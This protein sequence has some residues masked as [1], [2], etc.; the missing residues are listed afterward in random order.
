M[1]KITD[2]LSPQQ[3]KKLVLH[4]QKLPSAK[5]TGSAISA[6]LSAIE[7]LGYI[8]IDTI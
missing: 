4:S 6:S 2:S 5:Q 1:S 3:V 8:Q 7:H